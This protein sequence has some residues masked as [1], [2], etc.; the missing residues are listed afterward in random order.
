MQIQRIGGSTIK[1]CLTVFG[2]SE[3]GLWSDKIALSK[4]TRTTGDRESTQWRWQDCY[5]CRTAFEAHIA[6]KLLCRMHSDTETVVRDC[7]TISSGIRNCKCLEVW[8][9]YPVVWVS[10]SSLTIPALLF[11]CFV[12]NSHNIVNREEENVR[13]PTT[14]GWSL[15][16]AFADLLIDS[17]QQELA[18]SVAM[19]C[20]IIPRST[21]VVVD[22]VLL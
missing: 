7:V 19:V 6:F 1:H 16:F 22:C 21:N 15:I 4:T 18:W 14:S 12:D 3:M 13:N 11:W 20:F 10:H 2:L 17:Q 5:F 9:F 8:N